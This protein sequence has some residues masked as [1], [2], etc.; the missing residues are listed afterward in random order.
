VRILAFKRSIQ[1]NSSVIHDKDCA[2]IGR[3]FPK[4]GYIKLINSKLVP[5]GKDEIDSVDGVKRGKINT[6]ANGC[7]KT[8]L[9]HN[10]TSS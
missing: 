10:G 9:L 7:L 1:F 4:F 2:K 3:P 8:Y 6:Q 5:R